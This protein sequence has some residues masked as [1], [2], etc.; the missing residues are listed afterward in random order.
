MASVHAHSDDDRIDQSPESASDSV[1]SQLTLHSVPYSGLPM[2]MYPF[3]QGVVNTSQPQIRSKRR[4][5]KNACTNCQK[6]CKKC[7]DA[8]PCLRCVK[9]GIGE[10]CIDSQRKERKKGIKR[11][12][13]KKRDG[14]SELLS[15][16]LLINACILPFSL[17]TG[18]AT[19][20]AD[21][22][23]DPAPPPSIGMPLPGV[24]PAGGTPPAASF[25]GPIGYPIPLYGQYTPMPGVPK[26]GEASPYHPSYYVPV[27]PPPPSHPGQ[28]HEGPGYPLPSHQYYPYLPYGTVPYPTPYIV[29][30]HRPEMPVIMQPHAQYPGYPPNGHHPPYSKPP[31]AGNSGVDVPVNVN[32]STRREDHA[33]GREGLSGIEG[34]NM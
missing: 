28:E 17:A 16:T 27:Q 8:R 6:A 5:V 15:T 32:G 4:Q 33:D 24:P 7:D 3:A 34:R 23:P 25:M 18:R 29:S 9:Y 26:P 14:K 22:Q 30:H 10:E 11:G 12:P 13:Y 19:S 21:T 20:T 1:Q 2:H 31:S